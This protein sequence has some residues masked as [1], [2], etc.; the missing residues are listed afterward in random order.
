MDA[1]VLGKQGTGRAEVGR[2]SRVVPGQV[3]SQ[4]GPGRCANQ[5]PGSLEVGGGNCR[6]Q[7]RQKHVENSCA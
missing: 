7:L 3:S 6:N 5:W 2:E 1:F 4:Q